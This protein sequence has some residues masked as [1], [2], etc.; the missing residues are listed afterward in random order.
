MYLVRLAS[1]IEGKGW[2]MIVDARRLQERIN[3]DLGNLPLC[4]AMQKGSGRAGSWESE[5]PQWVG[6]FDEIDRGVHSL[7]RICRGRAQSTMGGGIAA[8]LFRKQA[9]RQ[10]TDRPR[11]GGM[12]HGCAKTSQG[13]LRLVSCLRVNGFGWLGRVM[14]GPTQATYNTRR[15]KG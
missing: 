15:D 13:G 2:A 8:C 7:K 9:G 6:R 1:R 12:D 14:W 10:D 4:R 5:R 11:P 3:R